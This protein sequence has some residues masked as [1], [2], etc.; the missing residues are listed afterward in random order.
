MITQTSLMLG[1]FRNN[2][3]FTVVESP[4]ATTFYSGSIYTHVEADDIE[5]LMQGKVPLTAETLQ[6]IFRARSI[7]ELREMAIKL[8]IDP[9]ELED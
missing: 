1:I 4:G 3:L 6:S 2:E 5:V 9:D 7:F 8:G